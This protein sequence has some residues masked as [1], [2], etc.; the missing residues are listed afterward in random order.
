MAEV[1]VHKERKIAETDV[2]L[3]IRPE[4][5]ALSGTVLEL[6]H[7]NAVTWPSLNYDNVESSTY[8]LVRLAQ[9]ND[10]WKPFTLKE[11]EELN[12]TFYVPGQA[13]RFRFNG[14]TEN[15]SIVQDGDLYYFTLDFVP[16]PSIKSAGMLQD[17][18][19]QSCRG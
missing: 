4:D 7:G 6:A 12:S 13:R 8:M 2:W 1:S 15:G 5:I 3:R 10:S 11:L 16:Y 14:L 18:L 17:L 9:L 19:H